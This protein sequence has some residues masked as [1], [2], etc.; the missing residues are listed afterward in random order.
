MMSWR[1]KEEREALL[2]RPRE[3]ARDNAAEEYFE[4]SARERRASS[5][6]VAFGVASLSCALVA[7]AAL[8]VDMLSHT[9]R[10]RAATTSALGAPRSKVG[11]RAWTPNV[12]LEAIN[13]Q[14]LAFAELDQYTL[15]GDE[16]KAAHHE[17]HETLFPTFSDDRY[18][19]G[20]GHSRRKLETAVSIISVRESEKDVKKAKYVFNRCMDVFGLENKTQTLVKIE[21]AV[22]PAVWPDTLDLAEEAVEELNKIHPTHGLHWFA[23]L[24]SAKANK[25][26][27]P[28][29]VGF[30][31]HHIGCLFSHMRMWRLHQK[32]QQPWTIIFES[33]GW[34]SSHIPQGHLQSVVDNA[35]PHADVIFFQFHGPASGQF[36]KQWPAGNGMIYMYEYN[37]VLG[38]AGLQAYIIGPKFTD[39]ILDQIDYLHGA[40]M[41]DA[42][43]LINICGRRDDRYA[44]RKYR[45]NCFQVQDQIKPPHQ[46]GGYLP[47]WYGKDRTARATD[48]WAKYVENHRRQ[49]LYDAA[50][51]ERYHA[52]LTGNELGFGAQNDR[53]TLANGR[54]ANRVTNSTSDTSVV[55]LGALIRKAQRD[56]RKSSRKPRGADAR[57]EEA[58]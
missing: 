43:L 31:S 4:E 44:T 10:N 5:R 6:L 51:N 38:A 41:V 16:L 3:T 35:P 39:K 19:D 52:F 42:W 49:D 9:A 8:T 22:Y 45:L 21:D 30:L 27:L 50:R 36:V 57:A 46:V 28:R 20:A 37:Q 7:S 14:A 12:P 53:E 15:S 2:A 1:V 23:N 18:M 11:S 26:Q 58:S 47:E 29:G 25:G 32:N 24:D 54:T 17:T 55:K 34:W 48:N 40:D 33:D 13:T 56:A